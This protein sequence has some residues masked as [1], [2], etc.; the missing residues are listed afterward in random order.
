MKLIVKPNQN[1]PNCDIVDLI[2]EGT[3]GDCDVWAAVHVDMFHECPAAYQALRGGHEFTLECFPEPD[4]D[5]GDD[6]S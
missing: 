5:T 6:E 3:N 2:T 4:E 1:Q